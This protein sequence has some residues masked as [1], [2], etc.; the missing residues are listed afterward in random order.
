MKEQEI[1]GV[2]LVSHIQ[3][4]IRKYFAFIVRHHLSFKVFLYSLTACLLFCSNTLLLLFLGQY[5]VVLSA[6]GGIDKLL[7]MIISR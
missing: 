4:L 2:E 1:M 5:T 6:L 7:A 3:S